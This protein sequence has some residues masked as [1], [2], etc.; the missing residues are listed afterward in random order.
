MQSRGYRISHSYSY[1]ATYGDCV[2][3]NT[4]STGVHRIK[5]KSGNLERLVEDCASE[6]KPVMHP[7]LLALLVVSAGAK[8]L[9]EA[10]GRSGC[11][12]VKL[13]QQ[14]ALWRNGRGRGM[15]VVELYGRVRYAVQIEGLS[16]RVWNPN[17]NRPDLDVW[18]RHR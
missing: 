17:T 7:A 13:R 18:K 2:I 4:G 1:S 15:K 12:G 9:I 10:A 11:A 6:I 16:R 14:V 3:D 5:I 8:I